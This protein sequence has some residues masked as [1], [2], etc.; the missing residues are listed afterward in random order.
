MSFEHCREALVDFQVL[1]HVV[2]AQGYARLFK[3]CKMWEL[4]V[5]EQL[6]LAQEAGHGHGEAEEPA[7]EE[8]ISSPPSSTKKDRGLFIRIDSFSRP[9]QVHLFVPARLFGVFS[10]TKSRLIAIQMMSPSPGGGSGGGA[11]DSVA[12][13]ARASDDPLDLRGSVGNLCLSLRYAVI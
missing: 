12:G 1:P 6:L 11:Q 4:E 10:P 13:G 7:G 9:G 3:V 2:D 8:R 5:V